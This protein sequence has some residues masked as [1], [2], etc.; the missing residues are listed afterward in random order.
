M[1]FLFEN[2]ALQ[3]EYTSRLAH[4]PEVSEFNAKVKVW[5]LLRFHVKQ[6]IV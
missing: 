1:F 4:F 3:Q 5:G 2:L 6:T